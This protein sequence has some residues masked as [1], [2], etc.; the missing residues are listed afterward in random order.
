M[1][2]KSMNE[3]SLSMLLLFVGSILSASLDISQ[4]KGLK[5]SEL[6]SMVLS[7]LS[8]NDFSGLSK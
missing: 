5:F 2:Q 7:S 4:V 6:N 8:K 3:K 1:Y